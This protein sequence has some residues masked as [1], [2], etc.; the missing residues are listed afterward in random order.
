MLRNETEATI[1][2][3]LYGWFDLESLPILQNARRQ[4]IM[5][6]TTAFQ[7][8]VP[9][10]AINQVYQLGFPELPWGN[11]AYLPT[12]MQKVGHLT[13]PRKFDVVPQGGMR[14]L[15]YNSARGNESSE[16]PQVHRYGE[17]A[18]TK[19]LELVERNIQ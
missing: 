19:L 18:T 2:A 11:D 3:D 15:A 13:Q 5:T 9:L 16:S 10:N 8:G 14:R 6:A 7:M 4:R 12:N 1:G 17:E